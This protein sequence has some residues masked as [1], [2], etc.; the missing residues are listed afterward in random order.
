MFAILRTF[1][2]NSSWVRWVGSSAFCEEL[3]FEKLHNLSDTSQ[4]VISIDACFYSNWKD[5][6]NLEMIRTE[7]FHRHIY[8]GKSSSK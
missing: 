6:I 1:N 3:R 5:N 8:T 4:N 2:A 7:I